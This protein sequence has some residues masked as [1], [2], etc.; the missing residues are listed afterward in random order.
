MSIETNQWLLVGHIVGF[1]VWLA[2]MVATL[3]LLRVHGVVEGAARDV[4][5]RKEKKTAAMMDAGASLAMVCGFVIAF[6]NTPIAFKTGGWLHVKLT[7][8]VLVIL[9]T[10]GFVRAQVK[11]FGRGQVR[12]IPGWLVYVVLL[13]AAGVIVLGANKS[14]LRKHGEAPPP[15]AAAPGPTTPA[16]QPVAP[17]APPAAGSVH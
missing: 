7:I 12:T 6:G 1:V 15:A 16:P 17:G 8:V 9:G 2:G 13:A 5:A 14:I 10:H 4:L 3:T 11:R